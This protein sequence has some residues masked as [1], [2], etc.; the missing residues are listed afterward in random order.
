MPAPV[1]TMMRLLFATESERLASVRRAT[2]SDDD[3]ARSSVVIMG[4]ILER[5]K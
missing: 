5:M 2:G 4:R 1:T 3:A